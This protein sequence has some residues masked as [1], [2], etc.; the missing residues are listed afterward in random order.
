MSFLL[1]S[2]D[3][4]E[5]IGAVS[6]RG[7]FRANDVTALSIGKRVMHIL[8]RNTGVARRRAATMHRIVPQQL[9]VPVLLVLR[10]G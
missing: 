4:L 3:Q 10:R 5:R 1:T 6:G 7:H 9:S 2:H 8:S